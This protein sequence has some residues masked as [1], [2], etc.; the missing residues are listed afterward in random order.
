M[1]VQNWKA[2][3]IAIAAAA[4]SPKRIPTT[5]NFDCFSLTGDRNHDWTIN[6]VSNI[7]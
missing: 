2:G 7:A 4:A 6:S 3:S 1:G 5:A